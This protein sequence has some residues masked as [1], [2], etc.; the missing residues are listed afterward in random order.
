MYASIDVG[1]PTHNYNLDSYEDNRGNMRRSLNIGKIVK[2]HKNYDIS[3]DKTRLYEPYYPESPHYN[4]K[5]PN[6]TNLP[7]LPL[8]P[9]PHHKFSH[10][11]R[12]TTTTV[13]P[14]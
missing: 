1:S 5:P 6:F 7:P 13:H 9:Q 3:S 11:I 14:G 2:V 10:G 8:Y 4:N 12:K